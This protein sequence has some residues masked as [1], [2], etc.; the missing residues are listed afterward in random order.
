MKALFIAALAAVPVATTAWV[1]AAPLFDSAKPISTTHEQN[2][3][4]AKVVAKFKGPKGNFEDAHSEDP[5]I[6]AVSSVTVSESLEG[7]TLVTTVTVQVKKL[8][9]GTTKI[10]INYKDAD[11][12]VVDFDLK[13]VLFSETSSG[14]PEHGALYPAPIAPNGTATVSLR[15]ID[16]ATGAHDT[17]AQGVATLVLDGP[18][19]FA[20]AGTQVE[21][22][23]SGGVA[24]ALVVA[25]GALGQTGTLTAIDTNS[26]GSVGGSIVLHEMPL[27]LV[28]AE[29]GTTSG[30]AH[31]GTG[32][33]L[34]MSLQGCPAVGGVLSFATTS[35]QSPGLGLIGL[36]A[37]AAQIP[38]EGQ[39]LLIDPNAM[40][41]IDYATISGSSVS[42]DLAM[43]AEPAL[44]GFVFYG[45]MYAYGEQTQYTEGVQVRLGL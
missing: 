20:G 40:L 16:T 25:D 8:K 37:F 18:F 12:A 26:A 44:A 29:P 39:T 35:S 11:S 10:V 38:A 17:T 30:I 36:S 14:G 32:N 19:H 33:A 22:A 45:Q 42:Y 2:G 21:I 28:V 7:G 1:H 9:A 3:K 41:L 43:P 13:D 27:P 6:A 24:Q 4:T 31:Y 23:F 15:A 5:E 34:T